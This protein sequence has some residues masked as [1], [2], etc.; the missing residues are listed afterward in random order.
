MFCNNCGAKIPDNAKF[1][2]SCGAKIIGEAKQDS[3]FVPAKCTGCGANLKVD[4]SLKMAVCPFCHA[5]YVV[6]QAIQNY[7]IDV[8]CG[9]IVNIQAANVHM[10]VTIDNL[11]IRA[12]EF[13]K[14]GNFQKATEYY[15]RSLDIDAHNVEAKMGADRCEKCI[16]YGGDAASFLQKAAKCENDG[17]ISSA[18][19]NYNIALSI[20][21][22]FQEARQGIERM[23]HAMNDTIFASAPVSVLFSAGTIELRYGGLRFIS[24]NG[25][26]EWFPLN[27][28]TYIKA[29]N[30]GRSF[31]IAGSEIKP[32]TFTPGGKHSAS[33][34]IK[35]I[36]SAKTGTYFKW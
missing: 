6:Q 34:W 24:N 33:K 21:P 26:E 29:A 17:E 3:T 2:H 16:Q 10:G 20:H 12:R 5:E 1:C 13:E 15:E 4:P 30:F 23:K 14:S 35:T 7:N 11:L 27:Q 19:K 8:K 18:Y 31:S 25:K 32:V 36:A 28:I 9:G 22:D